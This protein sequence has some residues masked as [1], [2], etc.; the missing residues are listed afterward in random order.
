[1]GQ[2]E[3]AMSIPAFTYHPD[4]LATGSVKAS[5]TACRCCGQARGYIYTGSVYAPGSYRDCICPWC[6][7]D[8][9]AAQKFEAMFSDDHP[10]AQAGV[11][12]EVIEEVTRRTPGYNSWQQE[13]WLSCC[14]DACE[15]HGDAP[16]AELQDFKGDALARTLAAWEWRERDWPQF[17]QH[18]EPGGNPAVYKFRCRH[19]GFNKY[20]V[21][22]T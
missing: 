10:L 8:G 21:D 2:I 13:V 15:F 12:N 20:A 11:P 3:R 6:I 17:V 22:F 9:S 4:P 5:D 1:L 16:C 19:C 18:Y 7:A 14:G